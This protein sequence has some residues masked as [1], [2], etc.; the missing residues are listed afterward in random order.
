[1]NPRPY[2]KIDLGHGPEGKPSPTALETAIS[3]AR[4]MQAMLCLHS[5]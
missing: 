5:A 4:S 1:M 2:P 3:A